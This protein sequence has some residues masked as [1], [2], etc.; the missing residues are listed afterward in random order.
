MI[1][2]LLS[3]LGIALAVNERAWAGAIS[4]FAALSAI[5]IAVSYRRH[6]SIWPTLA[7]LP[8]LVLILWAMYGSYS[9]LIEF[10][11]FV[12]LIAATLL[13]WR[14]GARSRSAA[15]DV[16]WI[17]PGDL[18]DRLSRGPAPVIID[19]RGSDEFTGPLSH[20][21]EARN[22][23]VGELPQRLEELMELRDRPIV[24]VCRTDKRSAAAASVLHQAGFRRLHV[25][26]GGMERWNHESRPIEGVR[27]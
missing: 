17:E 23:P 16:W 6:R 3:L 10:A 24:L 25:L 19:V 8:G 20:I 26:R 4:L 27:S 2:G 5:A 21:P 15:N 22:L 1:I 18:D 9:R 12:L 7:A 13:D 14:A 11:G